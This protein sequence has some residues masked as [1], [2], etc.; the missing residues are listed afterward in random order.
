MGEGGPA[1]RDRV[2]V[3][4][5]YA[6]RTRPE[7]NALRLAAFFAGPVTVLSFDD[8]DAKAAGTLRAQLDRTELP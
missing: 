6:G 2:R 5:N 8:E 3:V 1:L 4:N 7:V